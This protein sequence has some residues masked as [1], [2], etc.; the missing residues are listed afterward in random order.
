MTKVV[1]DASALLALINQEEG[2][3]I[4]EKYLPG[5]IMSSINLAEVVTVLMR[6][7]IPLNKIKSLLSGIMKEIIPFDESQ[8]YIAAEWYTKSKSLG[9]SLGDRACLALASS[10]KIPVI[11]ADRVWGKIDKEIE[12]ILLR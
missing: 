11:T 7:G 8:A 1:L 2:W 4:V 12:V 5:S 9:L 3:E 6:L 10:Q